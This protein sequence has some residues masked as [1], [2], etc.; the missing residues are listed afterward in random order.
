M[1]RTLIALALS[2]AMLAGMTS[3]VAAPNKNSDASTEAATKGEVPTYYEDVTATD[4]GGNSVFVT[5]EAG[6][7]VTQVATGEGNRLEMGG[8]NTE[9]GWGEIHR[10]N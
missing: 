8:A 7:K 5:D 2:A 9:S 4:E 1:K 3:C 10:P 6:E